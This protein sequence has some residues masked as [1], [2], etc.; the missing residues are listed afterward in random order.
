MV[1]IAQTWGLTRRGCVKLRPAYGFIFI[2]FWC[3]PHSPHRTGREDEEICTVKNILWASTDSILL[4]LAPLWC[5]DSLSNKIERIYIYI[6][7]IQHIYIY[8]YIYIYMGQ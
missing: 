4:E 7:N 1:Y 3:H 2:P 8:I 6:Y 5:P